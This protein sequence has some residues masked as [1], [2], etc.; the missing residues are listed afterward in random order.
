MPNARPK[1]S[2]IADQLMREIRNN[3]LA[4]GSLLPT[5]NDLMRAYGVSRHTVRVAVQDLKSR[6]IV[7]SRQG[8]GSTVISATGQAAF[9]EKI[10]SI[11]QLIA[12]GH[13]TRRELLSREIVE[14]DA[15]T[16]AQF[17]CE[18]GRRLVKARMLRR[19][20]DGDRKIALV[21]LWMNALLDDV[22]SELA[23]VQRSAAEIIRERFGLNTNVVE[24]TIS[25]DRLDDDTA[26]F[27]DAEPGSPALVVTRAYFE[28]RG[29]EPFLLARSICRADAFRVVS[30]FVATGRP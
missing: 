27:I 13:E 6:G 25:A 20:L 10:Q 9:A 3:R 19:S 11:D 24:Q 16:A 14:A 28:T 22:V 8:Q 17:G 1:Y 18:P 7:A 30:T 2:L 29:G 23:E 15:E 26:A 5:E 12:F 21:T 4:V